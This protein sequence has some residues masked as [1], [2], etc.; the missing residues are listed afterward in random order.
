[1]LLGL[2]TSTPTLQPCILI[3]HCTFKNFSEPMQFC[4][5]SFICSLV[6]YR[7]I[8]WHWS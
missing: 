6:S 8:W 3:T 1:V 2:N 4:I 5:R 7:H